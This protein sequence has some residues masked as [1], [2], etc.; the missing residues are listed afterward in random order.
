M[1]LSRAVRRPFEDA[2]FFAPFT[3]ECLSRSLNPLH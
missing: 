2:L 3:L 1:R